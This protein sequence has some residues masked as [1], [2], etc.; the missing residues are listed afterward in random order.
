MALR[1][2]DTAV[3]LAADDGTYLLHL[4]G[5]IDLTNGSGMILA[6][7]FF[8]DIAQCAGRGEI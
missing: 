1:V 8:G 3:A 7:V 5:D 6:A 2:D 4:G